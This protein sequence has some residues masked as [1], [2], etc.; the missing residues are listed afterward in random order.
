MITSRLLS[1]RPPLLHFSACSVEFSAPQP[2]QMAGRFGMGMPMLSCSAVRN[3]SLC[4]FRLLLTDLEMV[5]RR[6]PFSLAR[7]SALF[8]GRG[9]E[10]KSCCLTSFWDSFWFAWHVFLSSLHVSDDLL[11]LSEHHHCHSPSDQLL[12]SWI[13]SS[14]PRHQL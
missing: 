13:E 11:P 14:I 5:D 3:S 2:S 4:M 10:F 9:R 6:D 1:M 7:I 8:W 12:H